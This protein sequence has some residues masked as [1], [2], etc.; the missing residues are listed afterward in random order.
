MWVTTCGLLLVGYYL[1]VTTCGLLLVGYYLWACVSKV[2]KIEEESGFL[3]GSLCATI[4][5][6]FATESARS[7]FVAGDF[8]YR[9]RPIDDRARYWGKFFLGGGEDELRKFSEEKKKT[10]KNRRD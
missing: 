10:K 7:K 8:S 2:S 4:F 1:W 3:E 6:K 5:L 9:Y